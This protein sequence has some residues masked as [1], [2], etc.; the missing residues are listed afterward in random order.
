MRVV[1]WGLALAALAACAETDLPHEGFAFGSITREVDRAVS[2][3][4]R[5][6]P[7]SQGPVSVLVT[8]R[9]RLRT[10]RLV[11]CQDGR[12][13]C[14]GTPQG[15]AGGLQITPDHYV[16]TGLYGRTFILS[17]GGNGR[18]RVGDVDLP[19]A[20]DSD[21]RPGPQP[22]YPVAIPPAR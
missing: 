12:A 4:F 11:P 6:M 1:L 17:P 3:G 13:I 15:R 2:A 18:M 14:A 9:G 22:L 8:E 7:F 20:W 16:V 10:Y 5:H 19:L 21:N